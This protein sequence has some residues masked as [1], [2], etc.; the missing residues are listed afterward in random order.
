MPPRSSVKP[1]WTI[2]NFG[3]AE[4]AASAD[5]V[6]QQESVVEPAAAHASDNNNRKR[7]MPAPASRKAR[8]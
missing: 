1:E 7:K 4:V 8:R 2:T 5:R 3:G 6:E